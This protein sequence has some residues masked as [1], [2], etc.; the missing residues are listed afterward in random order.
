MAP[1]IHFDILGESWFAYIATI[2]TESGGN[3]YV[4]L[5]GKPDCLSIYLYNG[6]SNDFVATL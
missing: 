6:Q 3:I 2:L 1:S 4:N 5:V